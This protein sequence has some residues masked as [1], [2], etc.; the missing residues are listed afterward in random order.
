MIHHAKE[1]ELI[2]VCSMGKKF[3]VRAI[4]DTD[5]EANKF[6]ENHTDTAL[7]ACFGPFNIIANQ[8]A[9]VANPD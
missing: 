5:E 9:G 8:Y 4:S 7:I 3:L 6:M 2:W 1:S